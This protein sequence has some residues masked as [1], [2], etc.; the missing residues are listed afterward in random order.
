M[1]PESAMNNW[2]TE[3]ELT[4]SEEDFVWSMFRRKLAAPKQ[5]LELGKSERALLG[6]LAQTREGVDACRESLKEID[7]IV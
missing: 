7:I 1:E 2:R 3:Y 5:R 6:V 4:T